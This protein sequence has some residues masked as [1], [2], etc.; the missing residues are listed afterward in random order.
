M[1]TIHYSIHGTVQG[2]GFRRFVLYHANQLNLRGFVTNMEDGS[3]ECVAQG[4]IQ[5]LS[6]LELVLRQGPLNS[7]VDELVC[8]DLETEPRRYNG[9]RIL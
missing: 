8:T 7:Q 9:F 4:T 6:D 1:A 5:A 3:V 2:V